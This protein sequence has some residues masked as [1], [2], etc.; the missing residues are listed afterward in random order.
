M[1]FTFFKTL[2]GRRPPTFVQMVARCSREI[3]V[4]DAAEEAGC[5]RLCAE[6]AARL[7]A[8]MNSRHAKLVRAMAVVNPC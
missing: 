2:E 5:K 7:Q 8:F 3:F 6:A 4:F 1:V